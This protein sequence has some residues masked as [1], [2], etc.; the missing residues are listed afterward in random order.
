MPKE[1][2]VRGTT[3][4]FPDHYS[5]DQVQKI[6]TEQGVI[7]APAARHPHAMVADAAADLLTGVWSK[8]NPVTMLQGA[9]QAVVHPLDTANAML[10]GQ[11]ALAY[12]ARE[13]VEKGDYLTGLRQSLHYLIPL[14]GQ[15]AEAAAEK[16]SQGKGAEGG[17]ETIGTGTMWAGPGAVSRLGR[18]RLTPGIQQLNPTEQAAINF[19]QNRLEP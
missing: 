14:L 10:T 11:S 18:V 13:S 16:T 7:K 6:L 15:E 8:Y 12:K 19:L 2:E 5:D 4:E 1:Y 3:Y 9:S 17:G